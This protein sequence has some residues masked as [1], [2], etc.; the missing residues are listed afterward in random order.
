MRSD[1][2]RCVG[3]LHS[4]ELKDGRL[5]RVL[6]V[7]LCRLALVQNQLN[8]LRDAVGAATGLRHHDNVSLRRLELERLLVEDR[9]KV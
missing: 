5:A 1:D 7:R 8:G 6:G 4:V 9:V 2:P 3:M